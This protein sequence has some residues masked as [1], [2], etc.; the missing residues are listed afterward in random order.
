M[1]VWLKEGYIT[2]ISGLLDQPHKRW[3]SV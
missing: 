2:V 1:M 3:C